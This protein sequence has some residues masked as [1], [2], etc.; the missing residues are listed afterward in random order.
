MR[1]K[2]H[3]PSRAQTA[4]YL[5][6]SAQEL[7][8]MATRSGLPFVGFL[9]SMAGDEALRESAAEGVNPAQMSTP[10]AQLA[11]VPPPP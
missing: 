8:E 11:A 6:S 2:N 10:C 5:A 7:S 9:F 3:S 4:D 1:A